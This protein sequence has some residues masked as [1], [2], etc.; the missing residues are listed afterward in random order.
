MKL[1]QLHAL[2]AVADGGGIRAAARGLGLSQAAVT[3]ALR[4]LEEE[5]GLPLLMRH[6][7]GARLTTAGQVLLPRARQ[8]AT[9]LDSARQ[10]LAALRGEGAATLCVGVTPW[11]GQTL[12]GNAL[13]AFRRDMPQVH[14]ELYEGLQAVILPL[15]RTGR[16][17]FAL[18]PTCI[19]PGA[20]FVHQPLAYY[21]MQVVARNG[22]PLAGARSLRQLLEVDWTMNFTTDRYAETTH[23]LFGQHGLQI[24][25][26]RIVCAHSAGMLSSL[27]VDTGLLG[28]APQPMTLCE[29]LRSGAR[30]LALEEPLAD[31]DISIIR[32]RDQGLDATSRHFVHC[33]QQALKDN[34][35]ARDPAGRQ[36]A[37][38]LR[39][40][41]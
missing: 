13:Q 27:I 20:E 21:R 22:H 34:S 24:A 3:R 2:I 41:F 18:S 19:L 32:L 29:P 5:Q 4:E 39:L 31:G 14:L 30:A 12:L 38:M 23:E 7:G 15:L 28:Y 37:Q 8:V 16:M 17:Q 6:A 25:R 26:E 33:L 35:H 40:N 10:E 1:H 9:Q 36:L 11:F